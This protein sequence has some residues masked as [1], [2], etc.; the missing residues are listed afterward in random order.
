MS[1]AGEERRGSRAPRRR[2]LR[3]SLLGVIATLY[4]I[5]IP[6]YRPSGQLPELWWGF[7]DWVATALICYVAVALLNSLAWLLTDVPEAEPRPP[8]AGR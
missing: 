6:W 5:S 7:P 1:E 4:V 3:R 8:G 2:A